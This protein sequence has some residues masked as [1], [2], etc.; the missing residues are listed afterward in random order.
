MTKTDVILKSL[1]RINEGKQVIK[2]DEFANLIE[3]VG[4]L[5][6][7]KVKK[8]NV[9]I[10]NIIQHIK[11]IDGV[12]DTHH[13]HI[14]SIDGDIN[15]A[16]LHLVVKDFDSNVKAKVKEELNEH[17]IS[18]IT[19]EMETENEICKEKT[20]EIKQKEKHSH[21]HHN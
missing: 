16:T 12:I 18:H 14:W 13:V 2:K 20:C 4:N 17:G 11:E 3:L 5:F 21:C 7:N 10:N 19:I 9:D 6:I 8:G 1:N 15:L